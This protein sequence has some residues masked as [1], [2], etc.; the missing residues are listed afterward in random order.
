M[1]NKL[2]AALSL[3]FVA[4]FAFGATP[5][6]N[7]IPHVSS[8]TFQNT[9]TVTFQ[10]PTVVEGTGTSQ[11]K[12]GVQSTNSTSGIRG[13]AGICIDYDFPVVAASGVA[14]LNIMHGS[15]PAFW[16]DGGQVGDPCFL[17]TNVT[18]ADGGL[19]DDVWFDC[20][21][22]TPNR[23]VVRYHHAAS[24]GGLVDIGDA[25]Y[26]VRTLSPLAPF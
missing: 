5:R 16:L 17:G 13:S 7:A 25:G 8:E 2:L 23:A 15:T 19:Y 3:S 12:I 4:A 24:D 14:N 9:S 21:V 20:M 10:G 1:K 18:K 6:T 22:V 11:L 26:C